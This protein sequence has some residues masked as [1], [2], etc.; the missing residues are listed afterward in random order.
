MQLRCVHCSV[1]ATSDLCLLLACELVHSHI[2]SKGF[3]LIGIFYANE[4]VVEKRA[5]YGR[6]IDLTS[7]ILIFTGIIQVDP[8]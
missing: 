2:L 4:V 6:L 8:N 7:K 3:I 1:L 5:T